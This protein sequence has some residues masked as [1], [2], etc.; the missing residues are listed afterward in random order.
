MRLSL[1]CNGYGRAQGPDVQVSRTTGGWFI[2][3]LTHPDNQANILLVTDV[4]AR[5]VDIPLLDNVINIHFPPK[6]K[7]F[8][9]R[10]GRAAR[11]GRVGR[12]YNLIA[13]DEFPYL[14]DLSLFL[15]R[16]LKLRTSEK[17]EY[18]SE[19]CGFYANLFSADFHGRIIALLCVGRAADTARLDEWEAI[20]RYETARWNVWTGTRGCSLVVNVLDC[21]CKHKCSKPY[22]N[23]SPTT[24]WSSTCAVDLPVRENRYDG[25][26]RRNFG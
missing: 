24:Q 23:A 9:H 20:G 12:A 3:R 2:D 25:R 17:S 5:G 4:A 11:A 6:S 10:V 21:E 8:V 18:F 22:R 19:G 7:M 15:G 16:P 1:W 13:H 26:K 14:V